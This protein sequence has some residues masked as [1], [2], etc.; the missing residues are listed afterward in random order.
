M[1]PKFPTGFREVS[2]QE[3]MLKFEDDVIILPYVCN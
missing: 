3:G 2:V 1:L